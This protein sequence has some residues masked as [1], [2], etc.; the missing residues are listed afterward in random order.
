[1]RAQGLPCEVFVQ[2]NTYEKDG[3]IYL[4]EYDKSVEGVICSWA[5]R[6]DE[7]NRSVE[8]ATQKRR[9]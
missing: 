3:C 4:K 9:S 5:E 1:M 6:M 7:L 2:P 8:T